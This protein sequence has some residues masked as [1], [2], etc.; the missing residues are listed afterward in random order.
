M[1]ELLVALIPNTNDMSPCVKHSENN[2]CGQYT[3]ITQ[4]PKLYKHIIY[5]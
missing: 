2:E 1:Y 3:Q 4:C 5:V